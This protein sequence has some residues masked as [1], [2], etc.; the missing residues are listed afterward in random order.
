[1]F[2]IKCD[3][4]T[5]VKI[6]LAMKNAFL[7]G[8][9]HGF[10]YIG[11]ATHNILPIAAFGIKNK[12]G[13][14]ETKM[15]HV[16]EK[17]LE[18]YAKFAVQV[19]SNPQPGQT[20]I[21]N[22][23]IS[24]AHFARCCAAVAYG[25]GVKEVVMH[26]DDEKFSRIKM[27]YTDTEVLED[28][29]PWILQSYLNYAESE[30]GASVLRIV[31][32]DPE[33]YKGIDTEK[34]ARVNNAISRALKPWRNYTM[35][36][37]VQWSIVAV[38]SAAWAQKVY[39]GMD[40]DAAQE[41]L[42]ATIFDVCRV[43]G[44]NVVQAWHEHVEKT[45]Q[46]RNRLNE[47]NLDSVRLVSANGTD[48]TIGLADDAVWEGAQSTTPEGYTFIANIPTEEVFTAPHRKRTNG[49]VFGTKPYV[50][51]GNIINNFSL[52]FKDGIVVNYSAQ[53][54]AD[55]LEE[56]LNTDDGARSLGEI[57]LVPN[58]SPI[59]KSGVLFFNTLFDEN[60]SCHIALGAG[61]PGTIVG[62]STMTTPELLEKGVNDSL[63]HEDLMVGAPDMTITGLT[64]DGET[65]TI[66]KNGEW[67]I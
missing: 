22:A 37:K 63:V 42:W 60:A 41:R 40:S 9:K 1:M 45:V 55:L 27:Q 44:G 4:L 52:T 28:V 24:A 46:K 32:R 16:N 17:M 56:L 39:P 11:T 5:V 49:I 20:F 31:A 13:R 26:Y 29:K 53:T 19:G 64:K 14:T 3:K 51:N 66:F 6:A 12:S 10:N 8:G 30:G 15:V 21:I 50:Y 38:P 48:L 59:N 23:P 18:D 33:I 54:G 58:S 65:V 2:Y 43:S 67:A 25:L 35:N 47:L 7:F 34:I 61:Y 36:D 57:A 62:G